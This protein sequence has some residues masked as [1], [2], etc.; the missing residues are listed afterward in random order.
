[1]KLGGS[2]LTDKS[3][4]RTLRPDVL[5]R[6][7]KELAACPTPLVVVHGAGSFGHVVA[8]RHDLVRGDDGDR[9]RRVAFSRVHADVRDLD[10]HVREALLGAHLAPLSLGTLDL[11][12]LR[13]G[14]LAHLDLAPVR[15]A[16]AAGFTPV[17]RGDGVLD[18]TRGYGILSGDVLMVELA[19]ALRPTRAVFVTDVDGLFDRD[20]RDAGAT[21][22]PR[23]AATE[24]G[25]TAGAARGAD[26]TG[27]MRGKMER[28][29][30]VAAAG[31]PVHVVNGLAAG[32]LE[33]TLLGR[34][35][36]GTVIE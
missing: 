2:V 35:P 29:A 30:D 34:L 5:A 21:L 6:L 33:E 14:R 13:D 18:E 19:R 25:R 9:A 26:V 16:L 27:G 1:M 24:A 20:P 4:Y 10:G 23:I 7:A 3:A 11:A 8:K 17:L 31:V 12:R 36:V 22:L 32:R 28:A 15:A